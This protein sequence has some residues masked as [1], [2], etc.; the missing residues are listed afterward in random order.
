[1]GENLLNDRR[2]FNAGDHFHRA[3]AFTTG[4]D[5]NAEYSFQALSPNCKSA[6]SFGADPRI[7]SLN[8]WQLA[9]SM[10]NADSQQ[11]TQTGTIRRDLAVVRR[12]LNLAAR[13][14]RDEHGL[15]WLET[16]PLIQLPKATD[17]R[18]PYPL[19]REEQ[20]LFFPQ[21]PAHL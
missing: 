6:R 8:Y 17:A 3:A 9:G 7:N 15:T 2:I 20:G 12:V 4:L 16:P 1:M 18:K 5:V 19:A 11:G 10:L 13:L 21:L 14:W